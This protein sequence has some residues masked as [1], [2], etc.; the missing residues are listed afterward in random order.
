MKVRRAQEKD[1]D[2]IMDIY[3]K[4]R[5]FMV[6]NGNPTQW[7]N[8]YPS[9]EL[10]KSDVEKDGYRYCGKVYYTAKDYGQDY[11]ERIAFQKSK[12]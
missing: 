4:A 1:V 11:G 9:I 10:V 8:N 6:E 2:V 12:E 5:K 3:S 7:P